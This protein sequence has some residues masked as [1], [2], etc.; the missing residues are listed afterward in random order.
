MIGWTIFGYSLFA[1]TLFDFIFKGLYSV[2]S[3]SPSFTLFEF[4][5]KLAVVSDFLGTVYLIVGLGSATSS[6]KSSP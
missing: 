1:K 2:F 4:G 6:S 3:F 5:F